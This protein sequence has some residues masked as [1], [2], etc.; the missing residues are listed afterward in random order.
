MRIR[1]ATAADL[2]GIAALYEAIHD[3]E[4]SGALTIGWKRGVYPTRSTA[5]AA[6]ARGDLFVAVE[7][8]I[9]GAMVINQEQVDVY[10]AAPWEYPAADSEVMVLHT[11]TVLPEENGKGYGKAMM[12]YYEQYAAEHG[13]PY[14]RMD[15]NPLNTRARAFY[16]RLGFR[17]ISTGKT[18]FNGIGVVELLML[19][20]KLPAAGLR[21]TLRDAVSGKTRSDR[22]SGKTPGQGEAW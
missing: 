14:L 22:S 3:A 17:E 11:L 2:D 12:E 5:E 18:D 7:D 20:K 19:E 4:E 8:R 10:A 9:V 13:C 16:K 1:K 21:G 15:T 6:I